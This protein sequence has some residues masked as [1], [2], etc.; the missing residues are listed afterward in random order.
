MDNNGNRIRSEF[1][2][3]AHTN[4]NQDNPSVTSLINTNFVVVWES[5]GQDG[6]GYGIFGNIYQNDG[7]IVGFNACPLNCQSCDNK[8]NCITCDPNFKPQQ[9]GLC[10]CFNGFYLDNTSGNLCISMLTKLN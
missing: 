10:G 8:G 2:V 1:K 6:N 7:S 5:Q 3:N 4:A 9:S